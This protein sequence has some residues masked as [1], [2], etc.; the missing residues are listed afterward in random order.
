MECNSLKSRSSVWAKELCHLIKAEDIKT[1]CDVAFINYSQELNLN[2]TDFEQFAEK[3]VEYF[4]TQALLPQEDVKFL[5][6]ANAR[7]SLTKA[8]DRK[9]FQPNEFDLGTAAHYIY[10]LAERLLNT[11]E[12]KKLR[13]KLSAEDTRNT[14]RI[15]IL[16]ESGFFHKLDEAF[17]FQIARF[18]FW[19]EIE[20]FDKIAANLSQN[21][22]KWN[23]FV[24]KTKVREERDEL[25]KLLGDDPLPPQ[26]RQTF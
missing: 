18:E 2:Q 14:K 3:I 12:S 4:S 19:S 1:H 17:G 5:N 21:P 11:P 20:A 9:L 15:A 8:E 7:E 26:A 6:G 10:L 25:K 23:E 16:V 24:N 13:Q 22:V